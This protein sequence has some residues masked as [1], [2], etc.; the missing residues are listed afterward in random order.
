MNPLS[1]NMKRRLRN[2]IISGARNYN[3]YLADK[4]FKIVCEDGD[5]VE[6]RFFISD[7]KHLTGL[8]S[9]L[10]TMNFIKNVFM[11]QFPLVILIQNKNTIG[12][13]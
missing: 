8:Y 2:Y 11:A 4:V 10:K 12:I 7:F 1:E 9:D 6:I 13:H 3:K 5:T